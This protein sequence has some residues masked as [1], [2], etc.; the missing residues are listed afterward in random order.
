MKI[1]TTLIL[2][3][4]LFIFNQNISFPQQ[5]ENWLERNDP[6]HYRKLYLH[7]DREFYF[8]GDSVWFK[9]YY[10]DGQTHQF[11]SGFYSMYADLV[12]KNGRTI[13]SQVLPIANG[14]TV[15][16]IKIPHS[17]EPGNYLLRAFT[18]F[19]KSIGEDA[20]FNKTLKISKIKSS[21]ELTEDNSTKKQKR[22]P[23]I[24]VAF[25]PEGGFLLA[26]QMNIVGFKAV[27]ENGKSI[28]IRGEILDSKGE[29]VKLFATKY[30]GMD[31][32]YFNPQA[33]EIYKVKIEGYPDYKYEFNDIKKDGIK[34]EFIGEAK[35][36]LLI[37]VTTNSK[38]FQG[39]N[40][41]VAIMHRGK[42]FYYKK[43]VQKKKDFQIKVNQSVLPAGI[44]RFVLLDEQLKPVS[45]RLFFSKDFEVNNV[46]ISLNQNQY[47]T[48]SNVQ[49]EIFDEEE[50]SDGPYSSLSVAVVDENAVGENGPALNILY[51]LL[52]D[53]ELKGNI[54]S[55]ADYFKDE[56]NMPSENKLNLLMLTQGWSR[57]LWNI[58]PEKSIAPDFKETEGISIKGKVKQLLS[59]KPVVDGEIV[60]NIFKDDYF[61]VIEGKTDAN[62]RF[63]FDSIL[64]TDT[65]TV[66][67]QARNKKG[68]LSTEVF[69]DPVFEKSPGV[70]GQYLPAKKIV[71][72]LPVKIHRQKYFSELAMKEF[73]TELNAIMLEEV[74]VRGQKVEKDDGHFRIYGKAHTSLKVTDLDIAY[75]NVFGYLQGRVP[76]VRIEGDQVII[77]GVSTWMGSSSPLFLLDGVPVSKEHFLDIPMS[78]ID[79]VEVLK[80]A[81]ETAIFGMRGANGVIAILTKK[82]MDREY[83]NP[84]TI[85]AISEK[86]VG[87]S[88]YRE[89][90]SPNYTPENIGSKN[91]DHRITLYWNPNLITEN[92][93]ASL[94]FFTSDDIS[95]FKV[96]VEGVTGNG[97]I[98][99]GTAK[100]TVD[101]Y[102]ANSGK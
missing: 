95:N 61:N 91:P 53:S 70:S 15:G 57:Y 64:F 41:Y 5:T 68:K 39:E 101:K 42:V 43:F 63:S 30:K 54:E 98:C 35:D 25:L 9:A 58:I 85:G 44:N 99:L 87:Y 84:Y 31:K 83:V 17:L 62:G 19:Q 23:E 78:V 48:R 81:G 29:V 33:A 67:I 20:F 86:I 79:K 38:L 22:K 47:E 100:F 36:D 12:D 40:Y 93:K 71:T 16:N 37:K 102:H 18:D 92:G 60:L 75:N 94:S 72:E 73:S 89:F 21:F 27:D 46:K 14:I 69:L 13:H 11:I 8:Q 74:I 59:K 10:L 56:E 96:F 24:D 3:S 88:S 50:I 7:T 52:I 2:I 28:S 51:W 76:G 80:S 77:R 90:Y 82:G 4:I 65:A 26:G 6:I 49:L 45:E 66:F 32:I 1:L 55:P 97:K 34:I